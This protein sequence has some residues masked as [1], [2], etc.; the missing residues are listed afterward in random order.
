MLKTL[1]FTVS[2]NEAFYDKLSEWIGDVFYDILPEKGFEERDEQIYMAFQLEKAFKE[3]KTIFAEAGVGTG[4]TIVYLLY[5][6]CYARYRNQPAIIS[7]ADETLIE[8]LVKEEGDIAK[9][10]EALG[11]DIDVRLAKSRDQYVC[12]N[13]LEKAVMSEDSENIDMLHDSLP[14]FVHD[15]SSMNAFGVYG[16]RKEYAYLTNDEWNKVGWDSMQNCFSCE[17]RHRCGQTLS[18]DHYRK[19]QDLIVCSH[20]FFMEHVWTKESRKREGQLPLLPEYSAVIFDEGHLLEFAAQK[21]LTYKISED[22]IDEVLTALLANDMREETLLLIEDTIYLNEMFFR[23]LKETSKHI[24]GSHRYE[25]QSTASLQQKA[26]ELQ[27]HIENVLESLVFEAELHTVDE[28]SVKISEEYLEQISYS[29]SLFSRGQNAVVWLE[30]DDVKSSL[31]VM[32]RLVSDILAE[33][34]FSKDIP[35]IFSSATLSEK[36]SFDYIASSLGIKEY[37][38]F[39]VDSPFDYDEVMKI[40]LH[41]YAKNDTAAK[42]ANTFENIKANNGSTLVLFPS[43]EEMQQ[44]KSYMVQQ[45]LPY[46]VYF[47]GD[48]EISETVKKFQTHDESVFCTHHLWEGLDIPGKSL[49]NVIIYGLPFPPSDPVF[50]AKRQAVKQPFEEV[51]LP[52]MLLRLRQGI[53]RLIRTSSDHGHVHIYLDTELPADVRQSVKDVLPVEPVIL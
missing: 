11:L 1:P 27:D 49:N 47:E 39:S 45:E 37:A 4:K 40:S 28:Y 2:K 18:R 36:G 3:K 9:I 46:P 17:K 10:S 6:I 53:G 25:L 33:E 51:D 34:V 48:E 22:M 23:N 35:Y 16:D 52:Y 7:C 12:L 13:K 15:H 50:Q 29:F 31:V 5:A 38:H 8:Q 43:F 21:G 41:S 30:R 14:D 26:K 32:P 44:F 19:A 42:N 20:D 24:E